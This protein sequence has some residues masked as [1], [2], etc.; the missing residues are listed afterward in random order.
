MSN[1]LDNAIKYTPLGGSVSLILATVGHEACLTVADSGPGIPAEMRTRVLER[2]VRLDH[3]RSLPGNGLGLSLVDAVASHH[4]ARLLLED[5]HPGLRAVLLLPC[6][7]RDGA[8][9]TSAT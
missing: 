6:E 2:F 8:A 9:E 1:L 7:V 3:S 5:N 4:Q